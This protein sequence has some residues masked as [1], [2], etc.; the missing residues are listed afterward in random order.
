MDR[1]GLYATFG[2]ATQLDDLAVDGVDVLPGDVLLALRL[3]FWGERPL[4][5]A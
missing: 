5:E 4:I 3:S 2:V 1:L